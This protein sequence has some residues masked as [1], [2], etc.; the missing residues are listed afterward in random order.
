[1]NRL[2]TLAASA[3]PLA[4]VLIDALRSSSNLSRLRATLPDEEHSGPDQFSLRLEDEI[5][6]RP[7]S[8]AIRGLHPEDAAAAA[9]LGQ[10][11]EQSRDTLAHLRDADTAAIIEVSHADLVE[12]VARLLRNHVLGPE[13]PVVNGDSIDRQTST[14]PSAP[15]LS[16]SARTRPSPGRL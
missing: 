13:T 10:A 9:L 14:A 11:F 2:R 5:N 15:Y 7:D 1:M 3:R 6:E 16:S 8:N 4:E 12:P